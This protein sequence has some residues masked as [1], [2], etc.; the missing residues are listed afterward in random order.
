MDDDSAVATE[1][2]TGA[3]ILMLDGKPVRTPQVP[4]TPGRAG[5][6]FVIS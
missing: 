1:S 5:I 6:G 3:T 4:A 2:M